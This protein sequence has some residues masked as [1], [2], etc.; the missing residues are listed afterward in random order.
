MSIE[1]PNIPLAQALKDIVKGSEATTGVSVNRETTLG[2]PAFWRGVNLISNNVARLPLDC[3]QKSGS[4]RT[5]QKDHAGHRTINK[6]NSYTGRFNFRRTLTYHALQFGNGYAEIVRDRF[7]E[8]QGLEILDPESIVPY[9]QN[10]RLYYLDYSYRPAR[11]ILPENILHVKGLSHDGLTGYSLL[12]VLLDTFGYG[13]ALRKYGSIY[14]RNFASP[15]TIIELPGAFRD[16]DEFEQFKKHWEEAHKGLEQAHRVTVLTQGAKVSKYQ[17]SNDE[18]QFILSQ[19]L[20]LKSI[21]NVVGLSPSK[22]GANFNTSYG[23]LE[24]EHK[25]FLF[26]LEP[27][28]IA[29]EEE[30]NL[31]L[32][33]EEEKEEGNLYFEHER[34]ALERSDTAT[35]IRLLVEQLS[36]GLLSLNEVRELLNLE[37]IGEEGDKHRIPQNLTTIEDLAEAN[38][39]D[40]DQELDEQ[41]ADQDQEQELEEQDDQEQDDQEGQPEADTGDLQAQLGKDIARLVKRLERAFLAKRDRPEFDPRNE[42]EDH[43]PVVL[44]SLPVCSVEAIDHWLDNLLAELEAVTRDQYETVF[45]R[46]TPAE[47]VRMIY[48]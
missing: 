6:P 9:R 27:W 2:L 20:E 48:A 13:L 29:W 32:L 26:D 14:F 28:L 42:L 30:C 36:N 12:D 46:Q 1:N 5:V 19:E 25:A 8:P 17:I 10:G 16:K 24:H 35:E 37:G 22:L 34:K 33:T 31:K 23:S 4:G 21:A 3:Y 15:G 41:A 38:E 43:R 18:A 7:Y 39:Q 44:E 45:A 40:Q 11:R 47:I